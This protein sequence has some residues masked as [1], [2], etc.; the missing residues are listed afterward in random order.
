[1]RIT[2]FSHILST[3]F[4]PATN[5]FTKIND[6]KNSIKIYFSAT[7]LAPNANKNL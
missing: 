7:L 3:I 5:Y 4:I 2:K 1:M 6:D